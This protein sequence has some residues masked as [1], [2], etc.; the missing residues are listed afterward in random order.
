MTIYEKIVEECKKQEITIA[1]LERRAGLSNGTVGKWA[2]D[3]EGIRLKSISLIARAL[4]IPILYL[5]E[6]Q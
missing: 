6:N 5:I 1:E 3:P 4:D 2:A